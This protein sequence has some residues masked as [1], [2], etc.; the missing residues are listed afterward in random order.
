MVLSAIL[1]YRS[2]KSWLRVEGRR[3]VS[4]LLRLTGPVWGFLPAGLKEVLKGVGDFQALVV[5]QADRERKK[6]RKKR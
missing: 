4:N 1:S 6:S 2:V 3:P 5:E